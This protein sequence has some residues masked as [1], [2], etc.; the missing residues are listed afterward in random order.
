MLL[1]Y[2]LDN[3]DRGTYEWYP[4]TSRIGISWHMVIQDKQLYTVASEN[5]FRIYDSGV[6]D[7]GVESGSTSKGSSVRQKHTKVFCMSLLIRPGTDC[8]RNACNN[9]IDYYRIGA[10]YSNRDY[11]NVSS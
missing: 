1:K 3:L 10:H 4:A 8:Y 2:N 9:H 6:Y 11:K 5:R 7:V